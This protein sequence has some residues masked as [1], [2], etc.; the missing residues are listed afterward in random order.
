MFYGT[1]KVQK[2]NLVIRTIAIQ[3]LPIFLFHVLWMT[4]E[5]VIR[6][7]APLFLRQFLLWIEDYNDDKADYYGGWMW[8][9]LL[10]SCSLGFMLI[11]HRA[12]W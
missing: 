5:T 7:A 8:G 4:L 12:V 3:Y 9:L 1:E 6:L 2:K 11:H 10:V